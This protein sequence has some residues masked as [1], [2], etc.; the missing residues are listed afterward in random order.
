MNKADPI[1]IR[2]VRNGFII[3]PH[4]SFYHREAS[5]GFSND[6]VVVFNKMEDLNEFLVNHF[7]I[8]RDDT[9]V[10]NELG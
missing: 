3:E 8:R 1:S 6:E 7:P 9:K 10:D 2:Q 5:A 4:E